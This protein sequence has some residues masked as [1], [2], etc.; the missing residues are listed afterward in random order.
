MVTVS[1]VN[2]EFSYSL[3]GY[4]TCSVLHQTDS[5]KPYFDQ[6][7]ASQ[8]GQ[9]AI[10]S[11]FMVKKFQRKRGNEIV[12][13]P[14]SALPFPS[15]GSINVAAVNFEVKHLI[16]LNGT[17]QKA[18]RIYYENPWL[19]LLP[20]LKLSLDKL[21]FYGEVRQQ[22]KE[23]CLSTI[24]SIVFAMKGLGHDE[25]GLDALLDVFG[26]IVGDQRRFKAGNMSNRHPRPTRGLRL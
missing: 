4:P 19:K 10:S 25:E 18:K 8:V 20:H 12:V 24:E 2:T 21:S 1:D 14:G 9:D 13:P 22:P 23:G 3:N 11:G 16:V 7:L 6:I 15:K 5:V 17:W 26:S